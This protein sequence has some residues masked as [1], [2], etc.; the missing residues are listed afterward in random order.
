MEL[1]S[2]A[3][4]VVRL[5]PLTVNATLIFSWAV[6]AVLVTAAR[7]GA[8]RLTAAG[9]PGRGQ[10]ALELVVGSIR[11]QIAAATDQDP[12]PYLPFIATLYLFIALANLLAVV[13]GYHP[14][15][16]SLSTTLA[17]AGC[18]FVAVPVLGIRKVGL[19]RF[20]RHYVEPTPFMLPFRV[21]S[22][23]SRTVAMAVR[24]FGNIMSGT[25]LAGILLSIAPLLVPV[26]VH[27]LE[28]LIG[29]IQAYIF[30]VLATVYIASATRTVGPQPSPSREALTAG[31]DAGKGES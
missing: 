30:A 10:A 25:V 9:A 3:I 6:M 26:P 21:L 29:Q 7:L 13:P 18:V 2:D 4:A 17:L 24:L 5:G 16:A 28:L 14:P 11:R 22:E 20:L 1:S 23:V 19:T 27:L 8:R 31:R 12:G 15:T